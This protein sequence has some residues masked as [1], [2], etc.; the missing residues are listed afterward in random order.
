MRKLVV[1]IWLMSMHIFALE[2][3]F[4]LIP[5]PEP[6]VISF[7]EAAQRAL[8]KSAP[9]KKVEQGVVIAESDSMTATSRILPKIALRASQEMMHKLPLSKPDEQARASL[10]L[11]V[12]LLD[13]KSFVDIK[14]KRESLSAAHDKYEHE[15]NNLV[16]EVGQLYI[17]ALIAQA[18]KETALEEHKLYQRQLSHLERQ[19]KISNV[20]SLAINKMRYLASNAYGDYL[21]KDIEFHKSMGLLGRKIAMRQLFAL[22]SFEVDSPLLAQSQEDLIVMANTAPDYRMA[23]REFAASEYGLWSERLDFL[24]KLGASVDGGVLVPHQQGVF[25]GRDFSVRMMV[26]LDMPLFSGGASLA[27]L[28]HKTAQRTISELTLKGKEGEKILIINGLK[29]QLSDQGEIKKSA[30]LA[31]T[32]AQN[33]KDTALRL[34]EAGELADASRELIDAITN[35]ANANNQAISSSLKLEETKIKLLFTIGK[36]KELLN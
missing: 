25:G 11:S 34:Y 24:P 4:M 27:A 22:Q 23:R 6:P 26:T 20:R 2:G 10:Q 17:N 5:I 30:Q 29:R 18:L 15:Q 28:K 9:L 12:P 31:L 13:A 16:H 8:D 32:A 36:A 19:T 3:D 21:R 35:F 1:L 14:T 7:K 33:A